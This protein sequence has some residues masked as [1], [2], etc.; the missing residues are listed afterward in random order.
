MFSIRLLLI[1]SL[2][3]ATLANIWISDLD[4]KIYDDSGFE[5]A[6]NYALQGAENVKS[7]G[8]NIGYI[9]KAASLLPYVSDVING[10][11]GYI[12]GEGED[13]YR[14]TLITSIASESDRAIATEKLSAIF[15][16]MATINGHFRTLNQSYV[17]DDSKRAIVHDINN[18]ISE[19]INIFT[20]RNAI[21]RRH[22]ALSIG[23][24]SVLA[25][26]IGI[27]EP[28]LE[29]F[30]PQFARQTFLSCKLED[31]LREYR[32]LAVYRRIDKISIYKKSDTGLYG[33]G[34]D[35]LPDMLFQKSAV[36]HRS[37]NRNGYSQ[38]NRGDIECDKKGCHNLMYGDFCFTDLVARQ[39]ID[40]GDHTKLNT[41]VVGYLEVVRHRLE[42]AFEKPIE[43]MEN[44]CRRGDRRETGSFEFPHQ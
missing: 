8:S 17:G 38:S 26:V 16:K 30:E 23:A 10:L 6:I 7:M 15:A 12:S 35:K 13:L 28:I 37:Y 42:K 18:E 39:D 44:S 22:G 33:T 14:S 25:S 9:G 11:S 21:F 32:F 24:L 36:I 34:G 4:I 1:S 40:V 27:F 43:L 19:V 41:C 5:Q 29:I 2:F 3:V 31:I 20:D